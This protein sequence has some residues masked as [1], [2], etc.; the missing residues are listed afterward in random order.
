MAIREEK[1]G[2]ESKK[3]QKNESIKRMGLD[4]KKTN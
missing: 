4:Y 2:I 1:S 3:T